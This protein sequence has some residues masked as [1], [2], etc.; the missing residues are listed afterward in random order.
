MYVVAFA[1]NRRFAFVTL[2]LPMQDAETQVQKTSRSP[3]A[4]FE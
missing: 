2:F 1:L 3:G 4:L